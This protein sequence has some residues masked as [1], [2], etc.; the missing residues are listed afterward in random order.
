[1]KI[2]ALVPTL[3]Y[4]VNEDLS[5][6]VGLDYYKISSAQLDSQLSSMSGDGDG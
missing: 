1:V 5:V 2:V 3:V 6:G 4:K